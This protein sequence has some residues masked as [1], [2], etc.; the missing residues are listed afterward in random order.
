MRIKYITK[1]LFCKHEEMFPEYGKNLKLRELELFI[2]KMLNISKRHI[3][4]NKK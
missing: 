4:N 2:V 1:Y 3:S